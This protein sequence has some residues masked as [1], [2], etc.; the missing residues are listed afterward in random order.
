L[1]VDYLKER[2]ELNKIA[3]KV[4]YTGAIDEFFGYAIGE[5]EYRSIRFETEDLQMENYQGNAVVNYTDKDVPYTRII[6]HKWFN[7]DD[8]W[9]ERTEHTIISREYSQEWKQ[10]IEPYY[11]INDEKNDNLYKQYKT[12]A[13]NAAKNVI[14]AGRLGEYKYYDMDQAIEAAL[15]KSKEVF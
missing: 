2:E 3:D 8:K 9:S 5:L 4:I 1:G 14:F 13:E 7:S 6:E 15:K 10:G 12:L 11:P